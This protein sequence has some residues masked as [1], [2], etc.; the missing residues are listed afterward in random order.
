ML[1]KV[2]KLIPFILSLCSVTAQAQ[3]T[4]FDKLYDFADGNGFAD[5]TRTLIND[6]NSNG[7][8]F[9]A[10][11]L[12]LTSDSSTGVLCKVNEYGDTI[13][14]VKIN[15]INKSYFPTSIIK[16]SDDGIVIASYVTNINNDKT[17]Y[18]LIK[19]NADHEIMFSKTYGDSINNEKPT[20][21]INTYDKGYLI[22]GQSV[23]P[24]LDS[25]DMYAIKTDSLGNIEWEQY[26]GGDYF[27]AANS[28]I[29]TPDSGYL[30]LGWTKSFGNGGTDWYLVKIDKFGNPQWQRTY[31]TSVNE[32]G[33]G[34]VALMDGNYLMA[35]G[36][37]S[38][39]A[40]MRKIDQAGEVIWQK[41]YSYPTGSGGNYLYW[42]KELP[43]YSIIA[44]GGTN[45]QTEIDAGWLVK[46]DSAGNQL[47]ERK[48][49]KTANVELF[50]DFISTD[51]KGFILCGQAWNDS[52]NSQDAWLLKVDSIGC[53]YENCTVGIDEAGSEK[54]LVDVYPNPA[55]EVL[56]I[57]LQEISRYEV[58]LTDI[59][60]RVVY[61]SKIRNPKS[62]IEISDFANGIYL[63]TLE[64]S[65]QRTTVKVVIHH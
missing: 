23:V 16:T 17:D 29:Q 50:Y 65:E 19:I 31:G 40:R 38:G 12:N 43:D 7:W 42:A 39:S 64:N 55:N 4:Y 53:A 51:D 1:A 61:K 33:N 32:S 48:Y 35:G 27:E 52:N 18:S 25:A 45:N 6:T 8:Y 47:W 14:T 34:I 13:L 22:V 10:R 41:S 3:F 24:P 30:V 44:V 57:E 36:G 58:E 59:N 56:N 28:V 54:I 9:A 20:F 46:T 37:G 21:L 60:G 11:S 63:L 2:N 49:N 5:A 15:D 62:V 26:Y